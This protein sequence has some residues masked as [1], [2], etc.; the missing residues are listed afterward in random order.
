[1]FRRGR[2]SIALGHP[3]GERAHDVAKEYILCAGPVGRPS[4]WGRC[5]DAED[6]RTAALR[7]A[8]PRA[9][10]P[11]QFRTRLARNNFPGLRIPFDGRR[12]IDVGTPQDVMERS[13]LFYGC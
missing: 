10:G 12:R 13:V 11:K 6:A 9:S 2:A 5:I 8:Q 4:V 7:P 3:V 1:M